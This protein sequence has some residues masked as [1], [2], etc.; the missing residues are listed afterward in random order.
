V[1]FRSTWPTAFPVKEAAGLSVKGEVSLYCV[2]PHELVPVKGEVSLLCSSPR[3]GPNP[4]ILLG[5]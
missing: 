4:L 3:P 1:F 2:R 5:R